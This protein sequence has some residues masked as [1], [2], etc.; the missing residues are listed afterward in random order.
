MSDPKI[1][2][3]DLTLWGRHIN[4]YFVEIL[5]GEYTVETA[6]EDLRSLIGSKWDTRNK[7]EPE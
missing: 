2:E 7:E 5:N 3:D 6:R 4:S 1:T